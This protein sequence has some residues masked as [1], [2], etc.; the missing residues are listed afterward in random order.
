MIENPTLEGRG[1][2]RVSLT[3]DIRAA[4]SE[5]G[6]YPGEERGGQ[7]PCACTVLAPRGPARRARGRSGGSERVLVGKGFRAWGAD[8]LAR[9]LTDPLKDFCVH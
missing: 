4:G 7:N 9:R 8:H 1:S 5:A 3:G 2:E 6:R